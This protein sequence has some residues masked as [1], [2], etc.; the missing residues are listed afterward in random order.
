M[1]PRADANYLALVPND[2]E[3][4]DFIMTLRKTINP[5]LG[6]L[7]LCGRSKNRMSI[8]SVKYPTRRIPL[9]DSTHIAVYLATPKGNTIHVGKVTDDIDKTGWWYGGA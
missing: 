8:T 5:R 1:K 9:R 2:K 6:Q 7:K 4:W 3:G